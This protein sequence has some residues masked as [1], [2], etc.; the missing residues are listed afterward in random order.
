MWDYNLTVEHEQRTA[1]RVEMIRRTVD[2]KRATKNRT[3]IRKRDRAAK[4]AMQNRGA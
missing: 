1:E 4:Y 3:V 2:R